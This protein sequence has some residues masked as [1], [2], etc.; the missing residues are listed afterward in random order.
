MLN[1]IKSYGF[2]DGYCWLEYKSTGRV[3]VKRK[4]EIFY[5]YY[6]SLEEFYNTQQVKTVDII[7]SELPKGKIQDRVKIDGMTYV[8]KQDKQNLYVYIV[9]DFN[10]KFG[11]TK[12]V[13]QI[14][15]K[16][17]ICSIDYMKL[18]RDYAE[19]LIEFNEGWFHSDYVT[20]CIAQKIY[21]MV[22]T[23]QRRVNR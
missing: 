18:E 20:S 5:E 1:D 12:G 15:N 17:K 21:E 11:K 13:I 16:Q 2:E 23:A 9:K 10:K 8:I 19:S 4:D 6:N 7:L 3:A 14:F 22:A